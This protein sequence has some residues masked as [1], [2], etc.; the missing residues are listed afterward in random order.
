MSK[1]VFILAV[2]ATYAVTIGLLGWVLSSDRGEGEIEFYDRYLFWFR[3]YVSSLDIDFGPAQSG[4]EFVKMKEFKQL[5]DSAGEFNES[6][7]R[8][9]STLES[10]AKD[11]D[12]RLEEL[13][14]IDNMEGLEELKRDKGAFGAVSLADLLRIA[15][16]LQEGRDRTVFKYR[17][18]NL[19]LISLILI[20]TILTTLVLAY[21]FFKKEDR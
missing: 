17:M 1:K 19:G 16:E 10:M 14:G 12:E 21:E 15:L 13:A 9:G 3:G 20:L 11:I 4:V 5:I 2:V 18:I 8:E 7:L 6:L